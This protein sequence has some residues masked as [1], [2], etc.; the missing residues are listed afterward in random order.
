MIPRVRRVMAAL[1]AQ[2]VETRPLFLPLHRL[3]PFREESLRRGERLPVTERVSANS[4]MLPTYNQLT[5]SDLAR[6]ADVIAG[7]GQ[8]G[9]KGRPL[10]KPAA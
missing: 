10:A 4:L 6:I 2:N 9:F 3:P 7:A 5:D 1:A 8:K